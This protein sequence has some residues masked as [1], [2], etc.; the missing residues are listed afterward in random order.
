[1]VVNHMLNIWS[2]DGPIKTKLS[3]TERLKGCIFYLT[4]LPSHLLVGRRQGREDA[5]VLQVDMYQKMRITA[6]RN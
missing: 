5:F 6:T 1:M 4:A 2:E 3:E